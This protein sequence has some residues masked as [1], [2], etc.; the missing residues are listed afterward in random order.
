MYSNLFINHVSCIPS[1][2]FFLDHPY[3][4]ASFFLIRRI[5]NFLVYTRWLVEF[6]YMDSQLQ[7]VIWRVCRTPP[8]TDDIIRLVH[9]YFNFRL[10][11]LME[12]LGI[13]CV[14]PRLAK[15]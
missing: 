13:Y 11:S 4:Y 7:I 6:I 15:G 1:L 14:C 2:P 12:A 5:F 9:F 3:S 8:P 10:A